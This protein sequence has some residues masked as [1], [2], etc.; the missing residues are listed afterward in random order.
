MAL[1]LALENGYDLSIMDVPD[2]ASVNN[3]MTRG[4]QLQWIFGK[5]QVV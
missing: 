2:K 4:R 5:L 1:A 3:E